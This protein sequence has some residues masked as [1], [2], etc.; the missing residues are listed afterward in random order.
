MNPESSGNNEGEEDESE[1]CHCHEDEEED[2]ID[3]VNNLIWSDKGHEYINLNLNLG[4]EF[5]VRRSAKA[6]LLH[7][8]LEEEAMRRFQEDEEDDDQ[9]VE[10]GNK[11]RGEI[12]IAS[13]SASSEFDEDESFERKEDELKL[14]DLSLDE[15]KAATSSGNGSHRN[16]TASAW[17]KPWLT[18]EDKSNPSPGS[19]KKIN[20]SNLNPDPFAHLPF[21][22][23]PKANRTNG[24]KSSG[25]S[26]R[27]NSPRNSS[28][29][30]GLSRSNSQQKNLSSLGNDDHI[31]ST[32]SSPPS[33][34]NSQN[35]SQNISRSPTPNLDS[36]SNLNKKSS[37][38]NLNSQKRILFH[39]L[40][41]ASNNHGK[42]IASSLPATPSFR[43]SLK[44]SSPS[45]IESNLN[46][47]TEALMLSSLNSN[48]LS[49]RLPTPAQ[50]NLAAKQLAQSQSQSLNP[51]RPSSRSGFRSTHGDSLDLDRITRSTN[52]TPRA[53]FVGRLYRAED[54]L[55]PANGCLTPN[56]ESTKSK[57][58][59]GGAGKCEKCLAKKMNANGGGGEGLGFPNGGAWDPDPEEMKNKPD[60]KGWIGGDSLGRNQVRMAFDQDDLE[61]LNDNGEEKGEGEGMTS[62]AYIWEWSR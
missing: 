29:L 15:K 10:I 2:E 62:K 27:F 19:E 33:S 59:K 50:S 14:G 61:V 41:Q 46:K 35:Q 30:S 47:T 39:D 12:S 11:S 20:N 32:L 1:T 42:L 21:I 51:T 56:N 5:F 22:H 4:I 36:N 13:S 34:R 16:V 25:K 54:L 57:S 26:S 60:R 55:S 58:L 7:R 48:R 3:G 37:T 24:G 23:R 6:N 31:N 8:K 9:Q 38:S 44:N 53:R 43:S 49:S 17:K 45:K 18:N 52:G 40:K 28:P